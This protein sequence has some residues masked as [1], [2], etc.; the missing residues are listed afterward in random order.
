[1]KTIVRYSAAALLIGILGMLSACST[2]GVQNARAEGLNNRQD[3]IDSRTSARQG[4]WEERANR[5]DARA[6]A[7][8]DSW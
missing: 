7:W 5:Q 2:S 4:R 6:D 3:R 1:M 8:F